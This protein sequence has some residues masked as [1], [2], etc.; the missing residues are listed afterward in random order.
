MKKIFFT[1]S[2]SLLIFVTAS[3][4]EQYS[5]VRISLLDK[6][7]QQLATTGIDVEEVT[8]KK[9][10]FLE[11]DLSSSEIARIAEAGFEY[12]ILIADVSKYYAQRAA[13]AQ[14]DLVRNINDE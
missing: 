12:K 8:L 4:Q 11:T 5:K 1:L 14:A 7:I 2:L 9:G 10:V 3:A 6:S 13:A